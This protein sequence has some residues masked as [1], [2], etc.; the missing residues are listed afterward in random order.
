MSKSSRWCVDVCVISAKYEFVNSSD[1]VTDSLLLPR[2]L[3]VSVK[4]D[5]KH[6]SEI[7]SIIHSHLPV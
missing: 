7:M 4:R 2:I 5:K 6:E 1:I 3:S